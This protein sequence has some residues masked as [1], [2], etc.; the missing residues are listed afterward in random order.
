METN[1]WPHA[2]QH[3]QH[4]A[5]M[6]P[7]FNSPMGMGVD[8]YTSRAF[9]FPPQHAYWSGPL[10]EPVPAP[11]HN[12]QP[13]SSNDMG[14]NLSSLASGH[15]REAALVNQPVVSNLKPTVL[16]E[17]NQNLEDSVYESGCSENNQTNSSSSDDVV[18]SKEV[19]KL[20][21]FAAENQ[22]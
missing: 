15:E 4:G 18:D 10:H 17:V 9:N 5:Y 8:G 3:Q 16:Q 13:D 6:P 22:E 2:Q 7:Q 19:A 12:V 1:G 11:S 14:F 20:K 21:N